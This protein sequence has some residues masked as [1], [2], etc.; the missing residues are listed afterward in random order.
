MG[1]NCQTDY[2][3]NY[4][5]KMLKDGAEYHDFIMRALHHQG[6]ILNAL[7]SAKGQLIG[8]NMFG[9][10]IKHDRRVRGEDGNQ[11][12]GNLYIEVA[13]K[14]VPRSGDY[15][16]AGIFRSDNSWLYGIGDYSVFY[17][18]AI[19][20][21][22]RA[23]ASKQFIEPPPKDTSKGFLVPEKEARKFA[24]RIIQFSEQGGIERVEIGGENQTR[25]VLGDA[26]R[27]LFA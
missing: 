15:A 22:R 6:I 16:P 17:I 21:L 14:A 5:A 7:T 18:F 2:A 10:E 27:L 25:P 24:A 12:T 8:E 3:T 4:R 1:T 23:Y 26:Q 9:M 20:T 11:A 19:Q 13:E